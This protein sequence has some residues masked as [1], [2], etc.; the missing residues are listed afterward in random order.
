MLRTIR[1]GIF[2]LAILMPVSACAT[3]FPRSLL[4]QV[5]PSLRFD[6]LA[7]APDSYR[8]RLVVVGG[9]VIRAEPGPEATEL[10]ILQRPTA[11]YGPPRLFEESN[12][13]FFVRV[14][15]S[16]ARD[17]PRLGGLVAVVGEVQGTR[18]RAG[19]VLPYL[20]A[21]DIRSWPSSAALPYAPYPS[22]RYWP[23]Y[24]WPY[25]GHHPSLG[26]GHHHHPWG[27]H[28][29]WSDIHSFHHGFGH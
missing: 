15:A 4:Q 3:T 22:S 25:W 9:E 5:D 13:R 1:L 27:G 6:Q 21:R 26:L 16:V 23:Y 19:E 12:G 11:S 20:E 7:A 29:T 8:G 10:E 14:P 24:D 18:E 28:R 2:L 17:L